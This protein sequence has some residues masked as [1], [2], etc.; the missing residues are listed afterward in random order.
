MQ[1]NS[2]NK[3]TSMCEN[4][5]IGQNEFFSDPRYVFIYKHR[6]QYLLSDIADSLSHINYAFIKG[7]P[8]SF[9]IYKKLG[10]KMSADIDMLI[11][12]NSMRELECALIS[13]GYMT[14]LMPLEQ[15]NTRILSLTSSHQIMPYRKKVKE[16][17]VEIDL[18]FDIFWGEYTGKRVDMSEFLSDTIDIE[19]YG[20]K[21][22]TLPPIK[23]MIQ[24]V[25]H[26]YKD[27]NSI[28]LLATRNSIKRSMFRD[29]YYLLQNNPDVISVDKLYTICEKYG[30]IHYTYYILYHTGLLFEDKTLAKYIKAFHT[31]EGESLLNCYGLNESERREWKIDFKT[32]LE[33][34]L[35]YNFIKGELTEKDIEKIT[36]NKK[37]F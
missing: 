30:I 32:R 7:E 8:L 14:N 24:L 16:I 20:H 37:V 31:P 15:R 21:I 29:V 26:H 17:N 13:K 19:I 12:R 1:E 28:F 18:N 35:L 5:D 2:R 27:M 11:P 9:I 23:A 3:K 22:K 10:T 4:T 25:L 36:I 34:D 33:N 6:Y